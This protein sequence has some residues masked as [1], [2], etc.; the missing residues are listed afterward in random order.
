MRKL[1]PGSDVGNGPYSSY[2]L[3]PP[4]S[5]PIL[6]IW[7]FKNPI[8]KILTYFYICLILFRIYTPKTQAA[9]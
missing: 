6:Y 1:R 2:M 3:N 4:F 9:L 5:D 8:E 7:F